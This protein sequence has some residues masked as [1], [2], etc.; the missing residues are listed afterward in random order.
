MYETKENTM[1][2]SSL[3]AGLL[4]AIVLFC[5]CVSTA[6]TAADPKADKTLTLDLGDGVTMKLV[7]VPA[8]EF[9]MGGKFS[10]AESAKRFGGKAAHYVGE[11]PRHRVAIS[12]PFYIGA[13]ELTQAQ[14]ETVMGSKPYDGKML[15]K[16]GPDFPVSWVQ[17]VE[18]KEFCAKLSK[19]L[20][21][22]I[23]LPTEAQWEYACR[24]GSETEFCY[25][26]NPATVS[27]YGWLGSNMVDND[28]NKT[29]AR[30]GGLLKPNAWGLYDMHGN[31]WEWCADLYAQD[32]YASGNEV[33]PLCKEGK[34]VASRGGS[35][36]NGAVN[37]RSTARNSWTGAKYRHYN[38]GFRVIL[39]VE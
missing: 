30:K 28:K 27:D 2:N 8:G 1:K 31:V 33:D 25:G 19:K 20:G 35:W 7:L 29:Y 14:W 22:K 24:A 12:K 5:G 37:L 6:P 32:F 3:Q 9:M 26:D 39:E 11:H 16:T 36:Y 10:A 17:W 23:A 34:T 4:S 15:T 13:F 21:K 38:Y 18:A